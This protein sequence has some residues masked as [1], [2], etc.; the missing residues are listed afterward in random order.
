MAAARN[1]SAAASTTFFLLSSKYFVIFAML[2]VFPEP[3]MPTKQ[4]MKGF[5]L[6]IASSRS[7][8]GTFSTSETPLDNACSMV[9]STLPR[10]IGTSTSIFL[11][12]SFSFSITPIA[13]LFSSSPTSS[14]QNSSS[15]F[16]ALI[17]F[18]TIFSVS[19]AKKPFFSAGAEIFPSFL[20][21]GISFMGAFSGKI[22]GGSSPIS[23]ASSIIF[24]MSGA[25]LPAGSSLAGSSFKSL[26]S[27]KEAISSRCDSGAAG[28]GLLASGSIS[29]FAGFSSITGST[30]S[31]A[32]FWTSTSGSSFFLKSLLKNP[33]FSSLG[34]AADGS[35]AAFGETGT[36][37]TSSFASSSIFLV[38]VAM[39]CL[40]FSMRNLNIC[41]LLLDLGGAG[42]EPVDVL[43]ERDAELLQFIL[44]LIDQGARFGYGAVHHDPGADVQ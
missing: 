2:V 7:M 32:G 37:T 42:D 24:A 14:S 41:E 5:F 33:R 16:S 28:S 34:R 39:P 26:S 27:L 17:F 38:S 15:N 8:G 22:I 36:S 10:W 44:L 11:R 21:V 13:T 35:A 40:S 23:G 1:V 3:L 31:G 9:S 6:P 4:M 29:S 19:A 25:S 20:G 12:S 30:A 43:R 18:V